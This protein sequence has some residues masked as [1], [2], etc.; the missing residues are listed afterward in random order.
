M[1]SA[2]WSEPVAEPEELFLVDAVQ[3]SDSCSL[4]D[5][6]FERRHRQRAF[7]FPIGLWYYA[8]RDGRARYAPR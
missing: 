6:V 1:L 3:H 5:L 4:D 7:L 2:L 8:R